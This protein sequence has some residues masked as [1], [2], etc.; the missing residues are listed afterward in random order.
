MLNFGSIPTLIISN[1]EYAKEVLQVHD[2]D[3]CSRPKCPGPM[4]LSYGFKDVAFAPSSHYRTE[5][6]KL[7]SFELLKQKREHALWT[8]R[9]DEVDIML[10]GISDSAPN[11]VNLNDYIFGLVDGVVGQVAFGKSYRATQFEGQKFS[12]VLDEVMN[13]LDSFTA[14]DFFPTVG[15]YI[16]ILRG[17]CAKLDRRFNDLDGYFTRV[18]EAHLDP[19]RPPPEV[20]DL[21]DVLIRLMKEGTG[22]FKLTKEHIKS[23][24]MDT[25][26]GGIDTS[27]VGMVWAMAEVFMN[28]RILKKAQ[29]EVRRVVGRKPR[30]EESDM[31]HLHY[32]KMIIKEMFRM[33]P[34]APLLLPR[35]LMRDCK[36]GSD[37]YDIFQG[38]RVIVN[39]WAIG[40]DPTSW[41]NPNEFYPERFENSDIDFKGGHFQLIPFASGRRICPGM[42]M[43]STTVTFTLANLLFCFDW[44]LPD[45]MTR[46]NVCMEEE[47]GVTMHKKTPLILKPTKYNWQA[48]KA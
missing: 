35:E 4:K 18:L 46:E 37:E 40:R 48:A 32:I 42:A 7:F 29:A 24:L 28:P 6:R 5:M 16:D 8:A 21:V 10:Q 31:K 2:I 19:K 12:D 41:E 15:R 3:F 25:F 43:G 34:P 17:H 22:E 30:V 33:H 45:G 47:G 13:M 1:A 9:E 20:E 23:I 11:P 26:V 27:S 44:E 39:A 38:T 14:E 36:I